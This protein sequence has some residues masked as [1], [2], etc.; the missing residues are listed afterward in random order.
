[1]LQ[2]EA[3]ECGAAALGSVL[4]Y[5]GRFVA[6]EELRVAC[7]VSRN[8]SRA[9]DIVQAARRYGLRSRGFTADPEAL[10]QLPLPLVVH[11]RFNHFLVV[12][13]LGRHAVRV[14]DPAVGRSALS[15]EEF[16]QDFTGVAITFEPAPEFQ[17]GGHRRRLRSLLG[18]RLAGSRTGLAYVLAVSLM[19]VVPS[20]LLP[21]SARV[22]ID[23]YLVGG[24]TGWL[25][26]LLALMAA[27]AGLQA[28]LTFIQREHL[29][30]LQTRIAVVESSRF[31]RHLLRLPIAFYTQRHTGDLVTRAA[32]ND[33]LAR[34]LSGDL[35]TTLLS[36][37]T[38]GFYAIVM[39]TYDLTLTA[40]GVV[41]ALLSFAA[42]R[43]LSRRRLDIS[44]KLLQ[45]RAKLMGT[46]LAGLRM[47]ETLKATGSES[48]FFA[49]WAGEQAVVLNAER[50]LV[51][52]TVVLAAIPPFLASASLAAVLAIGGLRVIQGYLTIGF[53]VAFQL[54]L[55]A[56]LAPVGQLV[57]LGGQLQEV[58]AGMNRTDDV[59]DHPAIELPP[60][61]DVA[62]GGR[63]ASRAEYQDRLRGEVE[64][65]AVSFG[66][67]PLEPPLVRDVTLRIR[68]GEHVA[69]VGESGSGK[70]T[71]ARLIAGL[72]EPRDGEVLFDGRPRL[73]I[74]RETMTASLAMVDQEISLFAGTIRDNLTLWDPDVPEEDLVRAAI[75][76]CIHDEI[77]ARPGG[78]NSVLDE[79]GRDLSG[80]QRQRLEIAR[81]LSCNPSTLILDE[82][83]SA[84]DPLTERA[85]GQ[86]LRRRGCACLIVAQRLSAV[87]DCS[88]IVVLDAGRVVQ[89]GTHAELASTDGRYAQ[90]A[91][92]SR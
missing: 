56:F 77:L 8:G 23:G 42:L 38:V 31:I 70:S 6:L 17:Q 78:Y 88:Q 4:A 15:W 46:S 33:R 75:D 85:V 92:L 35:A 29:L 51:S 69:L 30:R 28:A 60:A 81:A 49:R 12:E 13:R 67:A 53:V 59:L 20:I 66:Y 18:R 16:E 71:I 47:I 89:R 50:R 82:A 39:A 43:A 27:A 73:Q 11:W 76:A 74:P 65:R 91:R 9:R 62:S 40:I 55:T 44:R 2:M 41:A 58:E 79:D 26:P 80:G 72:H 3:T 34:L 68:P 83:T 32:I 84:L 7:G 45:E 1:M 61:S 64:V 52:S 14:N 57:T 37:T 10:K 87:R 54:L 25:I 36:V 19:L 24:Q 22:F 5:H 90:L 63:S 21:I 86:N 48:G